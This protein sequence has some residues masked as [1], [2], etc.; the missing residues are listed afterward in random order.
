MVTRRFLLA[1]LLLC[2]APAAAFRKG[3]TEGRIVSDPTGPPRPGNGLSIGAATVSGAT[4]NQVLIVTRPEGAV[5]SC[6]VVRR[7]QS[8][9]HDA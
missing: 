1:L 6:G 3:S 8:L 7:G 5:K 4:P 9:G 2:G